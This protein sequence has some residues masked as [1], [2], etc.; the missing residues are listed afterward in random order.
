MISKAN[1]R[2][3]EKIIMELI[4]TDEISDEELHLRFNKA[5]PNS[6]LE[7]MKVVNNSTKFK[8]RW[9]G[10]T[11]KMISVKNNSKY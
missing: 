11:A 1:F 3:I 6:P 10:L 5:V 7:P 2:Q 9:S 4:G 8:I